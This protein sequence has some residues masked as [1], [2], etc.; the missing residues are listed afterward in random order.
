M[1]LWYQIKLFVF[2]LQ[3]GPVLFKVWFLNSSKGR[4]NQPQIG[5]RWICAG[6][7]S[8]VCCPATQDPEQTRICDPHVHSLRLRCQALSSTSNQELT[9]ATDNPQATSPAGTFREEGLTLHHENPLEGSFKCRF[10]GHHSQSFQFTG[11][12]R[13]PGEAWSLLETAF[14]TSSRCPRWCW[15]QNNTFRTTDSG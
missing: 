5:F 11:A 4:P 8:P 2:T 15:S 12:R 10:L 14:V 9:I 3:G 1:C 13:S 7:R 6:C